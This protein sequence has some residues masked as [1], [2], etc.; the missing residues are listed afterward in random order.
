MLYRGGHIFGFVLKKSP[1]R[2]NNPFYNATSKLESLKI[3]I[4][5][6]NQ[7]RQGLTRGKISD[8]EKMKILF[9]ESWNLQKYRDY[10]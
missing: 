2:S 1:V 5:G 7:H 3:F 9:E 10:S 6:I 4:D 8:V